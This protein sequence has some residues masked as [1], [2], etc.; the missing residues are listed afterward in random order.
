MPEKCNIAVV[1]KMTGCGVAVTINLKPGAD[2]KEFEVGLRQLFFFSQA[3]GGSSHKTVEAL[4]PWV[5]WE[6]GL[7]VDWSGFD[8]FSALRCWLQQVFNL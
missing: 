3:G 5:G 4:Q 7:D 6:W 8:L 1:R 2:C